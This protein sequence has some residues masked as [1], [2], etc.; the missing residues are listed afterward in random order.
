MLTM[1]M[2][3]KEKQTR[4]LLIDDEADFRDTFG[5][6]LE[7]KGFSVMTAI[8][9]QD[10]LEKLQSGEYDVVLLDLMMPRMDGYEFCERVKKNGQLRA[11]PIIVLTSADRYDAYP[12]VKKL[13]IEAYLEKLASHEDM[14]VV[15]KR[16]LSS[17]GNAP[18][19]RQ[20]MH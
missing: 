18:R 20:K 3:D 19:D 9:G 13:G 12:R 14:M 2:T 1:D 4:L 17:G 16:V 7:F 6:W 11:I 8:D 5:Q 15:L 10:G